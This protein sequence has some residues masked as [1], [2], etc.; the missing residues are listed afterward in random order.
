[1][2]D[3]WTDHSD[4]VTTRTEDYTDEELEHLWETWNEGAG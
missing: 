3:F 4:E 2:E 1:M